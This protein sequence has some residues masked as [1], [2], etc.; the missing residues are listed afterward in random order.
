MM[1]PI[2]T[3]KAIS[4]SLRSFSDNIDRALGEKNPVLFDQHAL[5]VSAHDSA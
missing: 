5:L 2:F 1:N 4:S 3:L